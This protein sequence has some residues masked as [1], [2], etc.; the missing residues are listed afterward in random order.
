MTAATS[1]VAPRP[2]PD[3]SGRPGVPFRRLFRT[4]LRKLTD[5]RASRWLLIAIIVITAA[6]VIGAVLIAKPD[7][8]TFNNLVNYTQ[9]PQKILLPV[10]GILV[11]TSE[12][13][14]RTGLIT[15]TLSPHRG[16]VLLAKLAATLCAGAVSALF[17]FGA[18]ALGN[19]VAH[20]ARA[21]DGSW[22]FGL[23]G[24]RDL[25][26]VQVTGLVQGFAF[27]ALLLNSAAAIV[28]YYVVPNVWALLFSSVSG[29][30]AAGR[31]VDLNTA[32]QPLYLHTMT[33]PAWARLACA[34]AI[35]VV[36]PLIIGLIR[37]FRS[38][39]KSN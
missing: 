34:V 37:V 26:L 5:T 2:A 16:R 6:V 15:F 8:L 23:A 3:L 28:L 27:G 31:W 17:A 12:W 1:I 19:L 29:L 32:Q 24:L 18:A 30:K 20:A 14:Q 4:E 22:S 33:G 38:E 35:W 36:L 10:L 9:S 39:V 7:K 13:S 11:V 25:L 21:G